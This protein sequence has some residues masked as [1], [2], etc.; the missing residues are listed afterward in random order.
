MYVQ[1]PYKYDGKYYAKID[2]EFIEITKEVA[3]VMVADYK[4][5]VYYN[6]K[7]ALDDENTKMKSLDEA[8]DKEDFDEQT[9]PDNEDMSD[10]EP[11]DGDNVVITKATGGSNNWKRKTKY[12]MITEC[13][14]L[15]KTEYTSMEEITDI[16]QL[17]LDDLMIQKEE[18]ELLYE[19]ISMLTERQ[20]FIIKAIYFEG[21][22]QNEVAKSM[23]ITKGRLSQL[24]NAA[25][26]Q[27][28]KLYG[29]N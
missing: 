9:L 24:L 19:K 29:L 22:K 23:G 21:R 15:D 10:M 28:R 12:T 2:N 7:W 5:Q 17:S 27:M 20:Q 4:K 6:K 14:L 26:Y 11:V 8:V 3:K 1:H 13:V 25:L 16:E 18:N